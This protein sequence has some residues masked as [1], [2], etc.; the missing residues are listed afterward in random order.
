MSTSR[1]EGTPSR[2]D[3][4][5]RAGEPGVP[6]DLAAGLAML[7]VVAIFLTNAGEVGRGKYDWLFPVVLS[8]A[9]LALAVVLVVRGVL[10]RGD[11]MPLS[12]AIFRGQ[13]GD[14]TVFCV[15]TIVYIVVIPW[16]GFWVASALMICAAGVF[17]ETRRSWRS[18]VVAAVVA[19]AAC[20][21]GYLSLTEIFYIK[22]PA[23]PLGW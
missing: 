9:L 19:V 12:P 22:F 17:L 7:V 11:R 13:G 5:V 4:P 10:G 2:A 23:G 18:A 15:L 16:I 20:T 21:A 6:R 8:Y 1:T 14:V 3:G